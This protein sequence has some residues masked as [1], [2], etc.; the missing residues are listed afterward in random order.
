[1]QAF[2][3][4][5][6]LLNMSPPFAMHVSLTVLILHAIHKARATCSTDVVG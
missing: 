4:L 2:E 5:L 6:R 3:I 1:M